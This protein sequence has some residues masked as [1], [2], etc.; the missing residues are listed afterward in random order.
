MSNDLLKL[1][2]MSEFSKSFGWKGRRGEI[3]VFLITC[4]SVPYKENIKYSIKPLK[5]M[6]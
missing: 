2:G 5:V 6:V 3:A 1:T 4:I